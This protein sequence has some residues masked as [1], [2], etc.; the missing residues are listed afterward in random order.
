[1]TQAQTATVR[2]NVDGRPTVTRTYSVP[3]CGSVVVGV[4]EVL[5]FGDQNF[6]TIVSWPMLGSAMVLMR[7]FDTQA[8]F[9]N[10]VVMP[11]LAVFR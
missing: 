8:A 10:E 2:F 11:P 4:H 5:G 6:R 1:M 7:P 9:D 3:A